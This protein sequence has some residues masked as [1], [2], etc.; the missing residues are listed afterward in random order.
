MG[1]LV[2]RLMQL[3]VL[4]NQVSFAALEFKLWNCWSKGKEAARAPT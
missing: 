3:A 1:S 4:Y 2:K